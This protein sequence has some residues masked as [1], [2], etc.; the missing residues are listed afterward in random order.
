MNWSNLSNSAR[1]KTKIGKRR[2]FWNFIWMH[3]QQESP[4]VWMQEAY[5]PWCIKYYSVAYPPLGYPPARSDLGGTWVGVPPIRVPSRQVCRECGG[6]RDGVPPGQT[7][8]GLMG[9]PW[10]GL[11]G[12]PEVGYPLSG[13]TQ[14]GLTVGYLRWGTPL[15]RVPPA[16]T[17][18]G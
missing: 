4:P 7:Q 6:T 15:I 12:V 16:W 10:P 3:V 5:Q 2:L 13:S 8:P 17:W 14:S 1:S 9:Y 18:L 11:T